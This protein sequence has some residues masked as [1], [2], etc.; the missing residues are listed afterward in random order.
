MC[1]W[2]EGIILY[3]YYTECEHEAQSPVVVN[4]CTVA[5][6]LMCPYINGTYISHQHVPDVYTVHVHDYTVYIIGEV[7]PHQ[8]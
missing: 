1:G 3:R 4:G 6:S 2:L 5:I 7:R 8:W